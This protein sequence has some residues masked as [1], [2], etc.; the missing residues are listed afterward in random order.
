MCAAERKYR[1]EHISGGGTG[2]KGLEGGGG[3]RTGRRN[4]MEGMCPACPTLFS[5]L[6]AKVLCRLRNTIY[7]YDSSNKILTTRLNQ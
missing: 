4:V 2:E 1:E 3:K 7:N 5:A 6:V